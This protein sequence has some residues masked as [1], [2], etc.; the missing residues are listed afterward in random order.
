MKLFIIIPSVVNV[1]VV[2]TYAGGVE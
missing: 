2:I 1:I